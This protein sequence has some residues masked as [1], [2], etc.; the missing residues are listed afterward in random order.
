MFFQGEWVEEAVQVARKF[1]KPPLTVKQQ[2]DLL[3]SRGLNIPDRQM[4]ENYLCFIGYYRLSAYF[5]PFQTGGD[6]RSREFFKP[7][8][9]FDRVLDLYIFDRKLRLLVMDAIEKIEVA[10]KSA[11]SN[12]ICIKYGSHWFM[13]PELFICDKFHQKFISEVKKDINFDRPK[14]QE[15][16]IQHYYERY[17][18]P[19]LPPSWMILEV[20]TLGSI[21]K[22]YSFLIPEL[23][24]QIAR[25]FG[26]DASIL[27]SWLY[28]MT[29]LRNLCAHHSRIWNRSFTIKPTILKKAKSYVPHNDRFFAQS[30]TLIKLLRTISQN[31]HWEDRLA[32]LFTEYPKVDRAIM[33]FPENWTSLPR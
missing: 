14:K 9:T 8:A 20:M 10:I 25:L 15:K 7:G 24:K 23:Q 5:I 22:L 16:F 12:I 32:A 26:I 3:T 21:S 6:V 28:S 31:T 4:A 33:G 1:D 19:A 30:F 2:I 27:K 11:I 13:Q 18:D 29:Y 17:D